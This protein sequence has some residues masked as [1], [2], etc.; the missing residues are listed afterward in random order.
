[1]RAAIQ[2]IANKKPHWIFFFA[3]SAFY[4]SF[5]PGTVKGMGYNLEN[6]IAADQ[7]ITNLM[8]LALQRPLE[9]MDWTRHGFLEVLFVL[10]FAI[11][12]RIVFGNSID[13]IGRVVFVQPIL[14]TSLSLVITFLWIRRL[15]GSLAWSYS[16]SLTAGVATMLWPY[17][18][19]GL[20][21]TQSFFVILSAYL[22]LA[23][24]KRLSLLRLMIFS[25]ACGAAISVKLNGIFLTPA[26]IYLIYCYFFRG[27]KSSLRTL[28]MDAPRIILVIAIVAAVYF[29]NHHY[30]AKYW[31][32]SVGGSTSYY[33]SM[34]AENPMRMAFQ[35][36][37]YFGSVNKSLLLYAP[38]TALGLFT[39][40]RAYRSDPRI[41]V[42]AVLTLAGMAGGFS[43]THMWADETWG[44]RYLHEAILPLT[45]CFALA[46]TEAVK[47]DSEFRWRGKAPLIAA[48]ILGAVISFL[49]SFFYYGN[50]HT[51]AIKVSQPALE[52][53]QYDP[54]LN[55]IE[56]NARLLKIWVG[57][58]FGV[59]DN[60]EYWPSHYNW[61]F[62]K[63]SDIAP[64]KSFDLRMLAIPL[65]LIAKG[66]E[67]S[68]SISPNQYRALRALLFCALFTGLALFAYLA[69][70][71]RNSQEERNTD[72]ADPS[73]NMLNY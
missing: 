10:P 70:I 4:L 14:F 24:E 31:E 37:S 48:A 11:A 42:F 36:L 50:L 1:M 32:G 16:L 57:G 43:L 63:P 7:T 40:P 66:R 35:L 2:E 12:S 26:I 51:A 29:A 38:V 44:P 56:F 23:T 22:A 21:T 30:S 6:I 5:T 60:P 46:K 3:L 13:W 55:H 18:Y 72:G 15:T 69:L 17:A 45:I 20:E 28:R 25:F 39:L 54:R 34:L 49:G 19:I 8:N 47:T 59:I 64:E 73:V 58:R 41:V 27:D 61:W 71:A 52:S 67:S 33:L 62:Q 53:M 9:R 65:P 68:Y